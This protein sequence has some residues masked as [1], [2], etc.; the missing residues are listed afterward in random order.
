[1]R[2]Y[3]IQSNPNGTFTVWTGEDAPKGTFP[4]E[5]MAKSAIR[6]HQEG[7]QRLHQLRIRA[8]AR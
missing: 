8:Q 6:I 3:T 7:D 4:T 2:T 1:M 5:G